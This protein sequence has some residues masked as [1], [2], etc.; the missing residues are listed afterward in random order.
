ML[1]MK[2]F[3]KKLTYTSALRLYRLPR[4][5]QI[6]RRLGTD[7]YSPGQGDLPLP[8]PCSRVL[9]GCHGSA[10]TP[11]GTHANEEDSR[12]EEFRKAICT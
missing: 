5:S 11:L 4:E 1:P 6:L 7:W 12:L 2:F 3:I 9:P 10:R 8:V